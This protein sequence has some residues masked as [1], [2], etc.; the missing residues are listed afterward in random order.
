MKDIEIILL[1]NGD[2]LIGQIEEMFDRVMIHNCCRIDDG[3]TLSDFPKYVTSH[4][5]VVYRTSILTM[6]ENVQ[7]EI[8]ISYLR[9]VGDKLVKI[10]KQEPQQVL[11]EVPDP[12]TEYFSKALAADEQYYGEIEEPAYI[13]ED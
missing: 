9:Q 4:N 5:I 1:C 6:S 3:D 7:T 10:E 2:Y 11:V 13:E 8:L 12:M